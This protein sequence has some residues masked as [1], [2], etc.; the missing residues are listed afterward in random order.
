[1][2]MTAHQP[3]YLPWLGLIHKVALSDKFCILDGVQFADRD[4]I[5]RNRILDSNSQPRWI[6]IPVYKKN[7]RSIKIRDVKVLGTDWVAVHLQAMTSAYRQCDYFSDYYPEIE[8][9]L[10]NVKSTFL[11]DFTVPLALFILKQFECFPEI[12]FQS[13]FVIDCQKSDLILELSRLH[14]ATKYF[15]GT[16]GINYLDVN[17]F[18]SIGVEVEFQKFNSV[19]YQQRGAS[20]HAGLSAI[21]LLF[22][23]GPDSR[24]Q[25]FQGNASSI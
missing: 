15:S 20:F 16:Q 9:S 8:F 1:M 18:N 25:L 12:S 3:L 11:I 24:N 4:F 17:T 19:P 2:I 21:D 14:S 5:H 13:D 10:K 23:S 22:H 6:T 7:H